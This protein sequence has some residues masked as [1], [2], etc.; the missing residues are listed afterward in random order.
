M[1]YRQ[2]L[3]I[4]ESQLMLASFGFV[5]NAKR[6][7]PICQ[8]LAE[9]K[10]ENSNFHYYIV[11][12]N[13]IE[14]L[15]NILLELGLTENVTIVGFTEL[16]VFKMYMEACDIP[17]NLRY[18]TCGESSGSLHRLFGFGK[19]VIV[20]NVG[21]FKEYP[22]QIAIKVSHGDKEVQDILAAIR[23]LSKPKERE[24]RGRAAIEYAAKHF[25]LENNAKLF[26]DFFINLQ[27]GWKES[28][29]LDR[30][31]DAMMELGLTNDSYVSHIA[32]NC[33]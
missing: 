11:G 17:I 31:A 19:P 22:D 1:E 21:A 33:F 2:M 24:R 4:P 32:Q 20:T 3:N 12:K 9:Y 25:S 10:K 28:D 15:P 8:A 18:P 14:D 7:I 26:R 27:Q 5:S 13:H 30:L 23:L 29:R 6:M 16:D